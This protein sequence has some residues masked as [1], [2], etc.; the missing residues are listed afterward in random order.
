ML[1]FFL[2]IF[3][4][5]SRRTQYLRTVFFSSF[6]YLFSKIVIVMKKYLVR[7]L[8]IHAN[9]HSFHFIFPYLFFSFRF[10]RP[11]FVQYYFSSFFF[12]EDGQ[13]ADFY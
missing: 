7:F 6:V 8:F 10:I 2:R 3:L 9:L 1:D 4:L 12:Y 11:P 5:L 13:P